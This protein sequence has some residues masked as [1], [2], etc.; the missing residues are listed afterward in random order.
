MPDAFP[1]PE[2][3]STELVTRC[4]S[5]D[6]HGIEYWSLACLTSRVSLH[7]GC[8]GACCST[9]T[10]L[11]QEQARLECH[12]QSQYTEHST[13]S[14]SAEQVL[15][16]NDQSGGSRVTRGCADVEFVVFVTVT[17]P[18]AGRSRGCHGGWRRKMASRA[19]A[20]ALPPPPP[21][22]CHSPSTD[23]RMRQSVGPCHS[24]KPPG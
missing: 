3:S 21:V 23:R 16:F 20:A 13:K 7:A 12:S 15:Y 10:V 22:I 19:A 2:R 14:G 11:C 8:V 18:I 4:G 17:R 24:H 9:W 1:D 6:N 5:A